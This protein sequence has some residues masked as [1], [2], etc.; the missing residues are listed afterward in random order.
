VE[1]LFGHI[2]LQTDETHEN[3]DGSQFDETAH[4]DSGELDKVVDNTGA[5]TDEAL[6]SSVARIHRWGFCHPRPYSLRN[7]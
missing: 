1:V 6:R 3:P 5:E 4:P 2:S 7:N